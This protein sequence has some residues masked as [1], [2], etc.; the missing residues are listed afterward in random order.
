MINKPHYRPKG[1]QQLTSLSSASGLTVPAG[2]TSCFLQAETQN[3]RFRDD[4][5]DPTSSV[6]MRLIVDDLVF[7]EGELSLIKFIEET[8][9][10]KVNVLYF[11]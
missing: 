2:S 5:T 8:A 3:V 10:A 1:Y 6:G 11:E 4:G 7:Y 9:S